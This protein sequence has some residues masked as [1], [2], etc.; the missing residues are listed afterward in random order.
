MENDVRFTRRRFSIYF[1]TIAE[2]RGFVLKARQQKK[3]AKKSGGPVSR[4]SSRGNG[5]PLTPFNSLRLSAEAV[6]V[7][8]KD[9]RD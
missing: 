2:R 6:A 4:Q 1:V 3:I 8:V 7:R 5:F 9:V